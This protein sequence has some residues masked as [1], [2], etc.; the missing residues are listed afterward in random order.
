MNVGARRAAGL[1]F[2]QRGY[3]SLGFTTNSSNRGNMLLASGVRGL[4]GYESKNIS[5]KLC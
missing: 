5:N 1:R 2:S 4:N 3:L